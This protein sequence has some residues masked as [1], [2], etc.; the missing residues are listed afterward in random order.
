LLRAREALSGDPRRAAD[1]A[2]GA[3]RRF[4]DERFGVPAPARTSEE[5]AVLAPPFALTTRW[6]GL[7]A[8]L[9]SLDEE[10]FAPPAA[11]AGGG[12]RV[13]KLLGEAE[14]FVAHSLPPAAAR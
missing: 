5:L 12:Q 6:L 2:S 11:L 13:A 10:R 14:A 1:G 8:L 9:R 4:L 7:A 3:L